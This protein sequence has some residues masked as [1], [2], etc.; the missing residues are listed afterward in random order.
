MGIFTATQNDNANLFLGCDIVYVEPVLGVLKV[1]FLSSA[2]YF[3][4]KSKSFNNII[5]FE[6]SRHFLT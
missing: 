4:E 6:H 1:V 3:N 5:I 2:L